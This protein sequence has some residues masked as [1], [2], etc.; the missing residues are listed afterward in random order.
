MTQEQLTERIMD[1]SQQL[2]EAKASLKSAHHRLNNNDKITAGIHEIAASVQALALQVKL[3]TEKMD[4]NIEDLQHS[5][6]RQG[7][8]IGALEKEPG[9]KW[10]ALIAQVVGLVVAAVVGVVIAKII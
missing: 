9:D 10:K 5:I 1:L 7:E 4:E 3:L 6:K 2:A 8:R